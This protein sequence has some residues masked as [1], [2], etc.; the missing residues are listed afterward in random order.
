MSAT[1]NGKPNPAPGERSAATSWS[2]EPK[3]TSARPSGATVR[4]YGTLEAIGSIRFGAPNGAPG[5]A[6]A[7]HSS[8][9]DFALAGS[10]VHATIASPEPLK[11]AWTTG[12]NGSPVRR[13]CSVSGAP[14]AP[15]GSRRVTRTWARES[16]V[17][18]ASAT[19]A[20]PRSE[21]AVASELENGCCSGAITSIGCPQPA[22]WLAHVRARPQLVL[23]L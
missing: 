11:P 17:T 3:T 1:V 14:N 9:S 16:D 15:P 6:I 13:E 2:P 4:S 5:G 19:S 21:A 12:G 18:L 20:S 23:E 8:R 22:A 7:A 10:T